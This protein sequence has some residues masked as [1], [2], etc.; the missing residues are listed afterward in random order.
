MPV[1]CQARGYVL[2]IQRKCAEILVLKGCVVCGAGWGVWGGMGSRKGRLTIVGAGRWHPDSP[3]ASK[4]SFLQLQEVLAAPWRD[5]WAEE[6]HLAH[7][8]GSSVPVTD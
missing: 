7:F 8:L 2:E 5:A 3:L 4:D 1:M 6:N